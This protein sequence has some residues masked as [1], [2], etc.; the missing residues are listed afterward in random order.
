MLKKNKNKYLIDL[1]Y[2]IIFIIFLVLV[3]SLTSRHCLSPSVDDA[4]IIK[5]NRA[6]NEDI[7]NLDQDNN[8]RN[9]NFSI[10]LATTPNETQLITQPAVQS[11]EGLF[12]FSSFFDSFASDYLVDLN[13]TNLYRDNFSAAV[14]FPPDYTWEK[15]NEA[16][17]F[18]SLF[19]EKR[20]LGNKCLE[21]IAGKL[22]YQGKEIAI[23][24]E[25]TTQEI[26]AI[27]LGA[28]DKRWLVGFTF[29][30]GE[31][32]QG[33]VYYFN[34][35][36]FSLLLAGDKLTS[37]YLGYFGFGGEED[38]FLIIYGAYRGIA[39]RVQAEKIIDVSKF[40]DYRIMAEGFR[41]EVIRVETG[42]RINWYVYSLT[43]NKPRLIKLWED[44]NNEISGE[45]VYQDL[46]SGEEE[47][48]TFSFLRADINEISLVARIKKPGEWGEEYWQIFRDRGFKNQTLGELVFNPVLIGSSESKIIIKKLANSSLGSQDN[49]C[50]EATLLF[51]V[52][53]KNW[54]V[55]PQGYYLNKDF[56]ALRLDKYFLKVNLPAQKDKF[57]SPFLN[58]V[59][60]DFYYQK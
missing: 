58:E 49:T 40:F 43:P 29:K 45:A 4:S 16:A 31:K 50:S 23:P 34:G 33:A 27:T 17:V 25:L 1:I 20:C 21:Q 38:D 6:N 7:I 10:P 37:P 12:T 35:K 30:N 52:D 39:Y 15:T 48:V 13:Q 11:E 18:D 44:T 8:N 2:V 47:K 26:S 51:S 57:Y 60:F 36:K 46:F 24:K 19:P 53:N 3:Y 28:L 56:G 32:Y 9:T 42:S 14:I 22:F 55:I 5:I 59:L 54:Q 41:P